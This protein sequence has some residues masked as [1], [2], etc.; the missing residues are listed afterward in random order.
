MK[1]GALLVAAEKAGFELFITTDQE[2]RYE[3][4]LSGR[5]I[6]IITPSTNNWAV[7]KQQTPSITAA[8]DSASSGGFAFVELG[9]DAG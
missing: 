6:A 4:N 3:Q 2:L 8:V 7:I 5:K 1:N 9:R